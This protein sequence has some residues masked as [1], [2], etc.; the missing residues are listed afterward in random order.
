MSPDF[1]QNVMAQLETLPGTGPVRISSG[2]PGMQRTIAVSS[3]T[4]DSLELAQGHTETGLETAKR[5]TSNALERSY[6][7]V[8][9]WISRNSESPQSGGHHDGSPTSNK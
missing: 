5:T 7:A 3:T 4:F 2:T 1:D 9:V 8:K 6:R